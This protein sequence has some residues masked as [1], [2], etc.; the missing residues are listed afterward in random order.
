[1]DKEYDCIIIGGGFSGLSSAIEL[2]KRSDL[3]KLKILILE[4]QSRLGG[5]SLTESNRFLLPIDLGCSLIHGYY[6]NRTEL[7]V[8]PWYDNESVKDIGNRYNVNT[9]F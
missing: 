3:K 4:S 9:N 8:N 7:I 2:K 1:M 6:C 5:R